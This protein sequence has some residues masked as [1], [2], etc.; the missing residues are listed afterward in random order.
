MLPL[1]IRVEP[2]FQGLPLDRAVLGRVRTPELEIA[3]FPAEVYK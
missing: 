1:F 2:G 3:A